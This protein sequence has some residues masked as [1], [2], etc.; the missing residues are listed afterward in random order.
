MIHC[1]LAR[2]YLSNS[3]FLRLQVVAPPL[4]IPCVPDTLL[5]SS[6]LQLLVEMAL[7]W[8]L[9]AWAYFVHLQVYPTF[10]GNSFGDILFPS[11]SSCISGA[12]SGISSVPR[13]GCKMDCS[14]GVYGGDKVDLRRL[15][16]RGVGKICILRVYF[17]PL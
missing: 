9:V 7:A 1:E 16:L 6:L 12:V 11:I 10:L 17:D 14:I 5:V 8:E 13:G 3:G 15:G 4:R 2:A